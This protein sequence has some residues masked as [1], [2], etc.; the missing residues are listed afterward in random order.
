MTHELRHMLRDDDINH[1]E[2]KQILKLGM[3]FRENRF[4]ARPFEGPQ[5]VAVLFDKPSTRTRSSFSIGVA[6]LGGY[7][8]VIDKSSSQLGRGEP[9]EDTARVLTRMAYG[10]VW[11]TFGQDRVETMAKYANCPVINALTD[12]FHPCQILADFLTMAQFRGGVDALA[13]Q[14]IAYL[15]DAANNMSNSYLLGGA[16]AGMHVRVAGPEGYLPD[17]Q[18]VADAK[19]IAEKTGGSITVT[20]DPQAAVAD[21]DCVFT[22]TWVSMGEEAEYAI[23]SKPFWDYQVNPELM[24]LAKPDAL[25]Q[26][27]LPA[28]RGKE[29]TA[30]VIDGPQSVV[31]DEAENRLHAQKA[32]M[33]WLIAWQRED[34]SLLG[35]L[36]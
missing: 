14:T 11:R 17:P 32:L 33:T 12:Q 7:P 26:H 8:L 22:D 29:V 13:G 18:I 15:G 1:E 9:V 5:A 21:A 30:S 24:K 31:W 20:T 35:D 28:Y 36:D 23:R 19:A 3:K 16:V 10:I 2:Q 4:Y 27:C 25:F 34:P 6:E